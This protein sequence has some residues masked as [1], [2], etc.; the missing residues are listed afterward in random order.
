MA[1]TVTR[2]C[3]SGTRRARRATRRSLNWFA[4]PSDRSEGKE[5]WIMPKFMLI[6]SSRPGVWNHLTAEQT[7]RRMEEYQ[8]WD[9][10]ISPRRLSGEKL[11]ND[12]GKILSRKDGKLTIVDGPYA[13]TK[14]VNG[15]ITETRTESL[16]EASGA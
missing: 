7:Q 14:E 3:G 9:E 10:K 6:L 12:G 1:R 15:G 2:P 16:D 8:G 4:R 13:D 11:G 5:D